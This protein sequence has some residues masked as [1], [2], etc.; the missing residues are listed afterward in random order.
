MS[1][2]EASELFSV[3]LVAVY[4]K[5]MYIFL[6]SCLPTLTKRLSW[7]LTSA[8]LNLSL[9]YCISRCVMLQMPESE[10]VPHLGCTQYFA[11]GRQRSGHNH[12]CK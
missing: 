4:C 9:D 1:W 10:K 11:K 7:L 2:S 8:S 12:V 5:C 6:Y 3:F